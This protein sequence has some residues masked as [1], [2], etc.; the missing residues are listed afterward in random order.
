[1]NKRQAAWFDRLPAVVYSAVSSL[2]FCSDCSRLTADVMDSMPR[3]W[4]LS[5]VFMTTLFVAFIDR[6]N[7]TFALPLMAEEYSWNDEQ[8]RQYGSQLMGLFYA[9]YGVANILLTPLAARSGTR[10]S[11]ILIICLWSLFT[12][13]GAFASQVVMLL[14]ATRILL[15]LS[16]GVHVPMMMTATKAWFPP[17]ERSRANSIVAGGIFLAVLLAPVLLVP[18]MDG[19]GWRAGFHVL[20]AMGLLIS[21]PLVVLFVHDT[22]A[23]HP[24][25]SDDERD[26]IA[27]GLEREQD[28]QVS[29]LTWLQAVRVPGFLLFIAIGACNNLIGLGLSSWIPTYFTRTRGIPFEDITWLVAGPNACSLLGLLVWATLGDRFN[30]RAV[31]TGIGAMLAGIFLFLAL[32]A[33]SLTGVIILFS[34]GVFCLTAFQAAEFALLQRILPQD[35]FASHAGLY[36]GLAIIVGGGLG[37]ALLS[38]V[39]G[40]GE[41]TWVVAAV[42]AACGLLLFVLSRRVNY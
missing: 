26:L 25:I 37:P 35:K 32:Q 23:G 1:M 9:A 29:G 5:L 8:V 31:V 36:N 24:G 34:L 41:G 10:R 21:L 15:G 7:I 2:V 3:R 12:A 30:R 22:P 17:E 4:Q 40:S 39:V 33:E 14:L 19:L 11:L 28:Q 20:A 6:L 27:A 38:P 13:L 16:E 42:A 18:L